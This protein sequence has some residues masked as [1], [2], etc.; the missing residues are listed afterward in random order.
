MLYQEVY[1]SHWGYII[2]SFIVFFGF[3][4]WSYM[5]F[6]TE[7]QEFHPIQCI[8]S[9]LVLLIFGFYLPILFVVCQ[10]KVEVFREYIQISFRTFNNPFTLHSDRI[11]FSHLTKYETCT[12]DAVSE[13]HQFGKR[14]MG[15]EVAYTFPGK[16]GVR[17]YYSDDKQV[18][19]S[20]NTNNELVNA[21]KRAL[22][23]K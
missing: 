22:L 23:D 10:F 14:E 12:Y 18:L 21:I 13:Y 20:S 19:I 16:H 6:I 1:K 2:G 7:S 17:L 8:L 4:N 15:N 5:K 11:L 9:V 3:G